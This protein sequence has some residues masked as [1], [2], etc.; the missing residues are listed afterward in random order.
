M[1]DLLETIRHLYQHTEEE[2]AIDQWALE[3]EVDFCHKL[4]LCPFF[5]KKLKGVVGLIELAEKNK[6][7]PNS[8]EFV[9]FVL[10]EKIFDSLFAFDNAEIMKKSAEFCRVLYY[11][12]DFPPEIGFKIWEMHVGKHEAALQEIYSLVSM[13]PARNLT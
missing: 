8:S 10:K 2:S 4:I 9:K 13:L 5:E 1:T 6:M 12:D 11:N 7:H 3:T